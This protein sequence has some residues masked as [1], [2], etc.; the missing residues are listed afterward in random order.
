MLTPNAAGESVEPREYKII[1]EEKRYKKKGE[2]VMNFTKQKK[3]HFI[4]S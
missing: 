2:L 1:P 4:F 3:R